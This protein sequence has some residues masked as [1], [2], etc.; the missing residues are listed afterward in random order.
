MILRWNNK[1]LEIKV[2]NNGVGRD[3]FTRI[4]WKQMD[5]MRLL[6]INHVTQFQNRITL[7]IS[8]MSDRQT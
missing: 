5:T 7:G 4:K 6:A 8:Y 2:V 1:T 3:I